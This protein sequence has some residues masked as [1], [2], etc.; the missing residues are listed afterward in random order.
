M[1]L[2][3]TAHILNEQ[4]LV[5]MYSV[6]E[7]H[8]KLVFQIAPYGLMGGYINL[9]AISIMQCNVR[10]VGVYQ[11]RLNVFKLLVYFLNKIF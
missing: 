7:L 2:K 10:F 9:L 1:G 5:E 8:N 6:T 3:I 11:R 4:E